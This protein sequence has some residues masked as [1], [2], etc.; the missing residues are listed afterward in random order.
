MS[1]TSGARTQL[2][3]LAARELLTFSSDAIAFHDLQRAFLLLRAGDVRLLHADLLATYRAPRGSD[4]WAEL[5]PDEPYIWEHLLYHL[6]GAGDGAAIAALVCDLAY[7]ALRSFR[8][9]PYAAESDL[10]QAAA[11]Y[12]GHPAIEWLLRL[13]TQSGHFFADQPTVGEL[14]SRSPAAPTTPPFP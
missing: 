14:P 9:G 12:P 3:Q 10:R 5:P 7:L 1:S 4:E 13:F 2:K 8:S 6:R 11:L